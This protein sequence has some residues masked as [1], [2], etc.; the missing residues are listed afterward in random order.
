L[1]R[2]VRLWEAYAPTW[3][4]TLEIPNHIGQE[5][6]GQNFFFRWEV[7]FMGLDQ[8]LVGTHE[9]THVTRNSVDE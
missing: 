3:I 8:T 6:R 1:E 9:L 7:S 2:K 5:S 4:S